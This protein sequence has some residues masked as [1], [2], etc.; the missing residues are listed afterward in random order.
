MSVLYKL[1]ISFE[2]LFLSAFHRKI[3]SAQRNKIILFH[4]P[5]MKAVQFSTVAQSSLTL[6]DPMNRSTPGV[7]VHHQLPEFTQTHVHRICD[8]IQPSH[9]S[10]LFIHSWPSTLLL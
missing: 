3:I 8:A 9:P 1:H 10:P 4:Y 2:A 6:C 7:P 5:P